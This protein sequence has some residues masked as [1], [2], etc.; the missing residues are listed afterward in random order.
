MKRSTRKWLAERHRKIRGMSEILHLAIIWHMHQPYYRD[1]VTG[2]CDLPA[3]R[4]HGVKDYYSMAWLTREYPQIRLT[5]NFTPSLWE[6]LEEYKRGMKDTYF[7]LSYKLASSLS[8]DDKIFLLQKFFKVNWRTMLEKFPRYLSL[9]QKRGRSY[10]E[11]KLETLQGRF[12]IQDYLDLQ[13]WFN[14]VWFPP[15][16]R[17]KDPKLEAIFRKGGNFT[18]DEK[19]VVLRKQRKL[20]ESIMPLYKELQERGQI[21]IILSPFYHPLIPLLCNTKIAREAQPDIPLPSCEFSHPEDAERQIEEAV[22]FYQQCFG[23]QPRGMWPPEGGVG[24]EIIPLIVRAGIKWIAS[25]EE[26]LW[27]SFKKEGLSSW[28]QDALY[29]PY[30][31]GKDGSSLIIIF[32][33]RKLSD[34]IGFSYSSWEGREA[35]LD[36][37]QRLEV[38]QKEAEKTSRDYL[39][40]VILDGENPW[41]YYEDNGEEFLPSLYEG[42]S[43]H[44]KIRT[45]TVSEYLGNHPPVG[46]LASLFAGSWIN[47]NFEIWIGHP[48][49]NRAWDLLCQTRNFLVERTSR[50]EAALKEKLRL[51][52]KSLFVAEGSDWYWW[53]GDPHSLEEKK[54]FDILYRKHLMNVYQL[55]G[56]EPPAQ[57]KSPIIALGVTP[58]VPLGLISPVIDG[59]LTHYYEWLGAGEYDCLL[60]EGAIHPGQGVVKKIWF[61]FN[62]THLY[63]RV[64][65][66]KEVKAQDSLSLSFCFFKPVPK[67]II[68]DLIPG[69]II[70]KSGFVSRVGKI[71]EASFTFDSLQATSGNEIAFQASLK[72]KSHEIE[73]YPRG[74]SFQLTI[75]TEDYENLIWR[76]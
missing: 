75:P 8:L 54:D 71:V 73:R 7:D 50:E 67:E 1:L 15:F 29:Q 72:R 23:R 70:S 66:Q 17:E 52:W 26:I 18:E 69:K 74:Y 5:F 34:L 44:P 48:E 57:L 45:T 55:L 22:D 38:I 51:A 40:T 3:V 53:Y 2:E 13:V 24:E 42:L 4:L 9:L 11:E 19:R 12:G 63:L 16:L 43:H 14:L 33:D 65:F 41:E 49:D 47:H 36:F 30:R 28:G 46:Q 39:V 68:L 37:I 61:G 31:I 25:D 32:R 56:E 6:Q 62:L 35:S 60:A 20:L 59:K 76:V 64:D 21:E 10:P 58:L 27:R